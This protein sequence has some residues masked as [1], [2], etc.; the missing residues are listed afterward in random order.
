MRESEWARLG[1]ADLRERSPL[2]SA[3]HRQSTGIIWVSGPCSD[4]LEPQVCFSAFPR[5]VGTLEVFEPKDP[6]EEGMAT[7]SSIL[8]WRIPWTEEPGG[9]QSWACKESDMTDR[10]D[11]THTWLVPFLPDQSVLPGEVCG[12]RLA[13]RGVSTAL[14]TWSVGVST[15]L[16]SA[17]SS[18]HMESGIGLASSF[19]TWLPDEA[20]NLSGTRDSV[21]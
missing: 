10:A 17:E 13:I 18:E 11:H 21:F 5:T 19:R 8:A 7:H 16:P 4:I 6:L 15:S 9:L 14:D 12:P 3:G 20:Q 2:G 1:D